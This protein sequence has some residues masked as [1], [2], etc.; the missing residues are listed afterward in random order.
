[1]FRASPRGHG[2]VASQPDREAEMMP[3]SAWQ[4]VRAGPRRGRRACS[5]VTI[6]GRSPNASARH[7]IASAG[8]V[9]EEELALSDRAQ[10]TVVRAPAPVAAMSPVDT[11]PRLARTTRRV[12]RSVDEHPDR[13]TAGF[14][15][16]LVHGRQGGVRHSREPTVVNADDTDVP[17]DA[18]TSY[19]G[20]RHE[21][22]SDEVVVG[23]DGG[24]FDGADQ[25]R[26]PFPSS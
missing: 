10:K 9:D 16:R 21:A 15:H 11:G 6:G 24:G 2:T 22:D 23:D 12:T 1:M 14:F 4:F 26:R 18:D 19:E 8:D 7:S 20:L 5:V 13:G 3:G 17:S 25:V